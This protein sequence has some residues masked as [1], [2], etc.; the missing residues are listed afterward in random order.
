MLAT[1]SST[2]LAFFSS[3]LWVIDQTYCE[4]PYINSPILSKWPKTIAR[5][6]VQDIN[7]VGDDENDWIITSKFGYLTEISEPNTN[8]RY[9]QYGIVQEAINLSPRQLTVNQ[10]TAN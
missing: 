9:T 6:R 4:C 8:P 2:R 3:H 1:C 5:F 10:L 7:P